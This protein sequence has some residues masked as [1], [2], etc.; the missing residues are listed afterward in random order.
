VMNIEKIEI[1]SYSSGNK[2]ETGDGKWNQK[3][4]RS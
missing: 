3:E 1:L 4:K 2:T